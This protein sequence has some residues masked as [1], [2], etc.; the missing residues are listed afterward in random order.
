MMRE[1][2]LNL[3]KL[4]SRAAE[5]YSFALMSLGLILSFVD[6]LVPKLVGPDS[7]VCPFS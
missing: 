7:K 2:E 4:K 1:R 5:S 6:R 3:A